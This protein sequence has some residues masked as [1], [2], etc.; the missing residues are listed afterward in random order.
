MTGNK[1]A[2]SAAEIDVA[3]GGQGKLYPGD[4]W[5]SVGVSTDTRLLAEGNLFIAL[6]GE[7]T[8]GHARVAE[9][10]EKGAAGAVV[11]AEWLDAN[12]GMFPGK[13]LFPVED[14]LR[15]MGRLARFHRE[16]FDIPV[17]AIAGSNGKTTTKEMVA[18]VMSQKFRTLKTF[19]NY[20]NQ[21]GVPM[22]LFS[23]NEEHEA[24]AIEIGTNEP[25]EIKILSEILQPTHGVITNIGKEHLEQL[26]D[27]DGVEMEETYLFGHLRLRGRMAIVNLDDERLARYVPVLEKKISFGRSGKPDIY[28][29]YTLD[30]GLHPVVAFRYAGREMTAGMKTHGTATALNAM[31]AGAVGFSLGIGHDAIKKAL[32]AYETEAGHGYAR[33]LIENAG[34]V[35]IINDCYNAN[36][37]S[38]ALSIDTLRHFPA[39][40]KRIAVL[41]DMREMGDAAAAE[42]VAILETAALSADL[43]ITYGEEM[44]RASAAVR[45]ENVVNYET[46]E[47]VI[48]EV[49]CVALPGDAILVKGSRSM[50]MEEVITALMDIY[51]SNTVNG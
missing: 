28:T 46:K 12:P 29:D 10:F 1:A 30:S 38:M 7:N 43:V 39:S 13:T 3:L 18:A 45:L 20:N 25:G 34:G 50:K 49:S 31:A 48:H 32:E 42:H 23:L 2:F 8:D 51:N 40:G 27:L 35:K 19:E 22:M 21:V 9:A 47:R 37:S 5:K 6:K 36:P 26:I 44:A 11:S 14:T 17:V 41:G 16:R 24:A 15:A 4:E 33:M